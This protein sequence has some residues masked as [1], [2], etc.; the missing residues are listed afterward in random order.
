MTTHKR[1]RVYP[2]SRR[3]DPPEMVFV[4]AAG[5]TLDTIHPVDTRYFADLA[6]LVAEEHED[7]VDLETAGML[8]T[9][10]IVKGEPFEPDER[11]QR[12]L[13]EAAVVGS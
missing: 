10:G 8:A 3:D 4:N 9:I 2:L 7:A 11:M 5:R 6:T 12:I 1:V 13:R